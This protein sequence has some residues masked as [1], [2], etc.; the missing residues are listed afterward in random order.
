MQEIKTAYRQMA[1][2]LHPDRHDGDEDKTQ[3]FKD[4]SDA[5]SI[6]SDTARRR[7]Y[8]IAKFGG[9]SHANSSFNNSRRPN[10]RKV[11]AP[12]APPDG[13][14]HDAQRHYDMHYGDGMY[15]DEMKRAHDK[16]KERGEYEYHSPLGKGFSFGTVDNHTTSPTDD[17][18]NGAANGTKQDTEQIN[19]YGDVHNSSK[20]QHNPYSKAAQGP[21]PPP[22]WLYEEGYIGEA[23]TVLKRKTGVT[24]RLYARRDARKLQEEQEEQKRQAQAEQAAHEQQERTR[25]AMKRAMNYCSS[26]GGGGSS[27][28]S[29]S[30]TIP[31]Y[32]AFNQTAAAPGCS[33]M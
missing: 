11:Y 8:D 28:S 1:L 20:L 16:A 4:A 17:N 15:R 19:G 24:E 18:V 5:Y 26:S 9:W 27:G 10:Y 14:W 12:H 13:K 6:L 25:A 21:P 23:K 2:L 31:Q 33:I 30:T 7:Q 29:N 32:Q 22:M 3:A